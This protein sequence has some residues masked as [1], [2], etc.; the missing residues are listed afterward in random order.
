MDVVQYFADH[1]AE[2]MWQVLFPIFL[3]LF[4]VLAFFIILFIKYT[5]G[6]WSAENPNPYQDETFGMPRGT[7]RGTLTLTLV[8]V[9]VVLELVNV[10]VVGF[11][12]EMHEFMVA[13]QMMIAFYFGSKVMHHVTSADKSKTYAVAGANQTGQ[14]FD[15]Q[16]GVFD[17]SQGMVNNPPPSGGGDNNQ[18]VG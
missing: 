18:A 10:R 9:T 5:F 15:Q 7:F 11:E 14:G 13:F 3:W 4:L 1:H 16:Q 17:Q 2:F 8:Y 12:A 6:N